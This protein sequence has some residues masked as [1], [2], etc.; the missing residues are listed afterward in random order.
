MEMKRLGLILLG[1]VVY[2]IGC[3]G[4]KVYVIN[5][6][7][8]AKS[9]KGRTLHLFP[10]SNVYL[11]SG[12]EYNLAFKNDSEAIER[13]NKNFGNIL[14]NSLSK[15]SDNVNLVQDSLPV[16]SDTILKD[17]V[18]PIQ[19]RSGAIYFRFR[20]PAAAIL[21]ARGQEPDLGL[22]IDRVE[23]YPV[24]VQVTKFGK[25]KYLEGDEMTGIGSITRH[26]SFKCQYVIW[27][28]HKQG[29]IAYGILVKYDN[30][31][32]YLKTGL[33]GYSISNYSKF[34]YLDMINDVADTIVRQSQLKGKK[35]LT[36]D[37]RKASGP[38]I[39]GQ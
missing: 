6:N 14:F 28:Y 8:D 23:F 12:Q 13:P 7:T 30:Y 19:G 10:L 5:P 32:G 37:A 33:E 26:L 9:I 15:I 27:D 36:I 17:T 20:Y 3:A 18:L 35:I 4:Q 31:F 22:Q 34:D 39:M 11:G 29:P 24:Q 16:N 25:T 1:S 21:R 2:L 38:K